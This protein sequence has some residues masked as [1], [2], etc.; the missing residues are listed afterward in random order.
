MAT[1]DPKVTEQTAAMIANMTDSEDEDDS[2]ES[3]EDEPE[4]QDSELT[5]F[6]S[7]IYNH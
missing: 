3:G 7:L 1:E 2:A 5:K 6:K 4:D